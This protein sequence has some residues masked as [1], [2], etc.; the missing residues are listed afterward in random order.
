M[1]SETRVVVAKSAPVAEP[2]TGGGPVA[3]AAAPGRAQPGEHAGQDQYAERDDGLGPD[4]PPEGS[5]VFCQDH[6]VPETVRG[7]EPDQHQTGRDLPEHRYPIARPQAV[8]EVRQPAELADGAQNPGEGDDGDQPDG[9]VREPPGFLH[10]WSVRAEPLPKQQQEQGEPADPQTGRQEMEPL[11]RLLQ[12]RVRSV[13]RVTVGRPDRHR[14]GRRRARPPEGGAPPLTRGGEHGEDRGGER[15]DHQPQ[16]GPTRGRLHEVVQWDA[17]RLLLRAEQPDR[18]A[19]REEG[20]GQPDDPERAG[21][22]AEEAEPHHRSADQQHQS[23]VQ[24]G[25]RRDREGRWAGRAEGWGD[26]RCDRPFDGPHAEGEH[27]RRL[28]TVLRRHRLPADG[29]DPVR[30]VGR[31][32]RRQRA[33]RLQGRWTH[34]KLRPPGIEHEDRRQGG[35]RDLGEGQPDLARRLRQGR[36]VGGF[37]RRQERVRRGDPR[38]S[39]QDHRREHPDDE[40]VREPL[41]EPTALMKSTDAVTGGA[42][43]R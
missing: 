40:A 4:E 14:D 13:G 31:E 7:A 33:R 19:E 8:E 24:G 42:N 27:P 12:E 37:R 3:D 10:R 15:R 30:Q 18:S 38:P 32:R 43:G 1:V 35:V 36:A 20:G 16:V 29:V 5:F 26:P 11:I 39:G 2:A 17:D 34:R 22:A 25:L 23:G 28:V 21:R 9:E 41:H 6:H